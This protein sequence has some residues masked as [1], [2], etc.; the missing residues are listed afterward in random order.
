MVC[1]VGWKDVASSHMLATDYV[2]YWYFGV[3]FH[4]II[5]MTS[6]NRPIPRQLHQYMS[7]ENQIR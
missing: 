5:V 6:L 4:N 1:Q 7:A 3:G 2:L